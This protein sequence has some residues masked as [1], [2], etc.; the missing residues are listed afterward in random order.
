MYVFRAVYSYQLTVSQSC[1]KTLVDAY[2][3]VSIGGLD[4]KL[5]QLRLLIVRQQHQ[6][7]ASQGNSKQENR[8]SVAKHYFLSFIGRIPSKDARLPLPQH[9]TSKRYPEENQTSSC[10]TIAPS[11]VHIHKFVHWCIPRSRHATH[12][13]PLKSCHITTDVAFFRTLKERYIHLKEYQ[14]WLSFK[15]PVALRFVKVSQI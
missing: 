14:T 10:K 3:E 11:H 7:T 1:G 2:S 15:R 9:H 8:I 5:K 13:F 6:H 4:S 12:M